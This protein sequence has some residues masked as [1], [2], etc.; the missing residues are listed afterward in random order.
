MSAAAEKPGL[1][2][3]VIVTAG[4]VVA[5]M[6]FGGRSIM[7]LFTVP[8]TTDLGW[9]RESYGLAMAIQNLMWG[10]AQPVVGGLADKYGTARV[11]AL[12]TL[13]YVAGFFG[14]A[15]ASSESM[16]YL[17]AGLLMGVGIAATSFG[18]VMAAFGRKVPQ[19]KRPFIF[20]VATAA[21]SMGQFVFAPLGQSFISAFGWQNALIYIGALLLLVIPLSVTLRGKADHTTGG[22]DM[23]FMQA[24]ARAWGFGSY[25]LLVIGFFVCGFHLAFITVHLPAYLVQCGLSP[26]VGSWSL[27][28]IGLFN[29]VGSLLAGYLGGRFPKQIMLSVIYLSR[30]IATG[31]FLLI[32]ISEVTAYIY[33]A[34]LGLLWLATVPLTAG[35]VTMFFGARYMGMLYGVAFLSHQIGSFFGVWLGGLAFD[36]TGSY[37]IIWYLGMLL[38]LGSAAIHLPIREQKDG[39]FDLVP[40]AAE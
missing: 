9:S 39:T 37:A 29:V 40:A 11:L 19:E 14:M 8:I 2:L 35:L 15:F 6:T 21:S 10:I 1:P 7:G 16:L 33:A 12:G 17:T 34:V 38:G 31:L 26:S 20:G 28:I 30:A 32:P 5:L 13:I 25:R 22:A 23:P 18:L 3:S 4:C 27:A 36:Q 24:L